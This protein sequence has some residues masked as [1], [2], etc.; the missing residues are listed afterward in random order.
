[1]TVAEA[2]DKRVCRVCGEPISALGPKGWP[3]DFGECL[4]PV[5]VTL[6]FGDE[7]A[8]TKCLPPELH[9][10]GPD[11]R[12]ARRWPESEPC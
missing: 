5:A 1:M 6:K 3:M 11:E 9:Y 10:H 8:H 4:Y 12:I 7:F 2:R